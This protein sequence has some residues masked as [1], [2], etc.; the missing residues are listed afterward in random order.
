MIG[1]DDTQAIEKLNCHDT[2][3]IINVISE[4]QPN[5]LRDG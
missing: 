1:D 2:D 4:Y 5:E 3:A